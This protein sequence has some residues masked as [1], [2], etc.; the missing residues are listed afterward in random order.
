MI[1]AA[2][3]AEL[4]GKGDIPLVGPLPLAEDGRLKT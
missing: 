3:F 2:L 4:D 1:T